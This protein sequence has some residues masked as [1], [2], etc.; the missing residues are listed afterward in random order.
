MSMFEHT[1]ILSTG[2]LRLYTIESTFFFQEYRNTTVLVHMYNNGI[3]I[4]LF[5]PSWYECFH[6]TRSIPGI[7]YQVSGIPYQAIRVAT[8]NPVEKNL[9]GGV[10]RYIFT[11]K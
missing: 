1:M 2:I 4:S 9:L 7:R 8:V 11:Q 3:S 6:P 10:Y 5:L